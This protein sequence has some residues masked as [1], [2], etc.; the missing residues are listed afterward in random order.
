MNPRAWFRRA[1]F[2]AAAAL[3]ASS[4][5]ATAP[6]WL[7][8]CINSNQPPWHPDQNSVQLLDSTQVDFVTPRQVVMV[9]RSARRLQN[10]EG[11]A[12]LVFQT[13]YN[14]DNDRILS[15]QAW[16][17][18]ANGKQVRTYER[19]A[20]V[21]SVMQYNHYFWD[22]ERVLAFDGR[23]RA[24][25]GGTVACEVKIE[26]NLGFPTVDAAFLPRMPTL[27]SVF[28]VT[29]SP[30][31]KLEWF[32]DAPS[33][34]KPVAG[35]GT[36]SL[37]WELARLAST[38]L[39]VPTGFLPNLLRAS[40]RCV[41]SDS[42]AGRAESWT[43]FSRVAAHIT[44]PCLDP[45]GAV[46]VQADQLVAG[47]TARWDR[48]R[49]LSEFVQAQIVYLAITL[50]KDSV[51]GYRPH[52]AAEVLKKRY[53]DC[54]DKATLL[55]SML[56]AV[57]ED[58]R[59][60]LLMA[61]NPDFVRSDWASAQFN[62]AIVA[63]PAD[64]DTPAGWPV[65]DSGKAGKWVIFDPTDPTT[66]LGVLS[67][68]DQGGFGLIVDRSEGAL[69][70]LPASEPEGNGM[71]RKIDAVLDAQGRL[72]VKVAEQLSG[73]AGAVWRQMKWAMP[74]EKFESMIEQLIHGANPLSSGLRWSD[75]WDA[76][77]ARYRL[78]FDFGVPAYGRTLGGGLVVLAPN[79]LPGGFKLNHWQ[80]RR[81]GVCWLAADALTEEVRLTLPPGCS[82]E[83]LPDPVS[84]DG[85]TSSCRLSYRTEGNAV[86]FQNS[87]RRRA[88]FYGEADYHLL[89]AFYQRLAEAERRPVIVRRAA[90]S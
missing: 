24:Q 43:D 59:T 7:Q 85:K 26:R 45:G 78:S 56:R 20:F 39:D 72:A 62:H 77:D 83:E 38:P 31:A 53:G 23:G 1:H 8:G 17:V 65:A 74:R 29:P 16:T 25:T 3:A 10:E 63:I 55:V 47:K 22:S 75:E 86:I 11:L 51:A 87:Y 71:T 61:E 48:I 32:A 15:A 79:I 88:G 90:P 67:P 68:G 35:P 34:R 54:K 58:G 82:V 89:E 57:G 40:A 21:D 9:Y 76:A 66:P 52:P 64:A 41:L 84:E 12:R 73:N 69:V 50:D 37:H 4:A 36:G 27:R 2:L 5:M 60:V 49:A 81:N 13:A 33:L 28:E 14:A 46:K 80:G 30:G 44:D 42:A 70:R 6:D 19:G 18:S